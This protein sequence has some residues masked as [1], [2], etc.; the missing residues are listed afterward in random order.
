MHR[1]IDA[2]SRVCKICGNEFKTI[3]RNAA[4]CSD[5]CRNIS[6]NATKIKR[7]EITC[8][9]G[10][11]FLGT[12]GSKYCSDECRSVGYK[13]CMKNYSRARMKKEIKEPDTFE[14]RNKDL[15][16]DVLRQ[17]RK[18]I[19]FQE[20]IN[21]YYYLFG[22]RNILKSD[23]FFP[24]IIAIDR[25]DII[26]R[27]EVEYHS[28]NFVL[29]GHDPER[30]D[31]IYSIYSNTNDILGVP[32]RYFFRTSGNTNNNIIGFGNILLPLACGSPIGL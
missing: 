32:V 4:Y 17:F 7:V 1:R 28:H 16:S 13:D 22:F 26:H 21:Q 31:Y 9:C 29:H 24:D 6:K 18:E 15:I 12:N 8:V 10:K 27:I 20:F 2:V 5:K 23:P 30:C 25:R 3:H 14:Y 11:I 19:E